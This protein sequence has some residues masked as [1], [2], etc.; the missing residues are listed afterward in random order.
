MCCWRLIPKE[1]P[2]DDLRGKRKAVLVGYAGSK[3]VGQT[4]PGAQPLTLGLSG[5][6]GA[7]VRFHPIVGRG[8]P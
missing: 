7:M 4:V 2:K 1:N 5:L 3:H 6:G 8:G